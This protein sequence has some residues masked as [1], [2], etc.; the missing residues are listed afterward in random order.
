MWYAAAFVAGV[1]VGV[2]IMSLLAVAG[3]KEM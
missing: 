3:E 2:F 1:F